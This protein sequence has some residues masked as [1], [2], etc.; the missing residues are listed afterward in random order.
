MKI[1][2]MMV[3]SKNKFNVAG[4]INMTENKRDK[5]IM[6]VYSAIKIIA[7]PEEEY[8]ILK[9]ET[10]SDS[11]SARSNGVRLASARLEHNHIKAKGLKKIMFII[12]DCITKKFNKVKELLSKIKVR[13][14]RKR[15][16]S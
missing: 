10:S 14:I 13:R 9:P 8:S 4:L 2:A 6:E 16:T 1:E 11:L 3:V 5:K 7:N 12:G 15:L